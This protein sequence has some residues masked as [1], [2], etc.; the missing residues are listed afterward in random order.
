MNE[1][2]FIDLINK[3]IDGIISAQ[4][5][6]GLMEYLEKNPEE[7]QKY[8]NLV[9]S[10]NYLE[11]F[12]EVEP[13]EDLKLRIMNSIDFNRYSAKEEKKYIFKFPSLDFLL[14]PKPKLAYAFTF[15]IIFGIFMFSIFFADLI[16]QNQVEPSDITGTMGVNNISNI[17]NIATIPVSLDKIFGEIDVNKYNS[18]IWLD[19]K[20]ESEF[21]YEIILEYDKNTFNLKNYSKNPDILSGEDYA[22]VPLSMNKHLQLFLLKQVETTTFIDLKLFHSDILLFK[23]KIEID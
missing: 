20:L 13:P 23:K 9:D 22:K 3:E 7:K 2:K 6:K 16:Y 17:E 8:Q 19:I 5:K 12:D 10:T 21:K 18:L 1:T 14:T 15:G 11:K 4:E